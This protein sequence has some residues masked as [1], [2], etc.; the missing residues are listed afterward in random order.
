MRI[1]IL[2]DIHANREA[3]DAVLE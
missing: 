3:F 1:A 2:S